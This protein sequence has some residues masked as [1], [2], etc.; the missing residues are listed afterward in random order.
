MRSFFGPN[1]G[2][3][4]AEKLCIPKETFHAVSED[5]LPSG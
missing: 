3:Y 2:K 4:G 5:C 1:G